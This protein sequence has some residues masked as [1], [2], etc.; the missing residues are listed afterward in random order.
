[1]KRP[2]WLP[3][4]VVAAVVAGIGLAYLLFVAVAGGA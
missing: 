2:G 4:A 1:M 3:E